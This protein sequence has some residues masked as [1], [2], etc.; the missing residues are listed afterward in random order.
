M[1]KLQIDY[2][3]TCFYKIVCKDVNIKDCYVGHTTDF[4]SR[5][6]G[7]KTTCNNTNSKS[8]NMFV[9]Q[10]VRENG[11]WEN[12][13]MIL[14]EKVPC[15]DVLDAKRKERIFIEQLHATLNRALPSRTKE[16]WTYDNKEKIKE[17]KHN[18]H[19]ENIERIKVAKRDA[20]MSNRDYQLNK[21]KQYYINNIEMAKAWKN[22]KSQ[23]E[24]GLFYT[25]ANRARHMMSKRHI[26][27]TERKENIQ[28]VDEE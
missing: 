5:R 13:D 12:F 16:E 21:S 4:N 7:H 3:K 14:I 9:Y 18:W 23:C 19:I 27:R 20:Y 25:N 10:F 2:S 24:C 17:Y 6:R 26:A 22:G 1:P 11:G 8:H 28:L 15:V